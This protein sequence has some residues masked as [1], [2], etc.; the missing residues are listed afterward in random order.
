MLLKN[1]TNIDFS[2]LEKKLHKEEQSNK[3]LKNEIEKLNTQLLN[4]KQNQNITSENLIKMVPQI[5]F[6][7]IG[8]GRK[9]GQGGFSIIY[10][11][12]WNGLQV[13]LKLIFDPNVTEELL[14]EFYNEIRMLFFLRHPNII[15]LIGICLKPQKLSILTEYVSNGS[16]FELLHRSK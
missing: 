12:T 2:D 13:A 9:I 10:Q 8:L 7:Q 6:D 14:N 11:A 5:D 15:L 3:R 4:L 16:L 1:E